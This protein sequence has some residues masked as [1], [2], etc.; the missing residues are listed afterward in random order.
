MRRCSLR[1]PMPVHQLNRSSIQR[2][3]HSSSVPG[4]TK[5]SISICSNS[6]SRK[7]KLPGV[8]SLRKER[9]I[10]AMPKGSLRRGGGGEVSWVYETGRGVLGREVDDG[11]LVGDGAD[12]GLE[13][14]VEHAGVGELAAAFGAAELALV[15]R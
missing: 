10:W 11:C 4:V 3:C 15:V 7:M 6:R 12:V 9:P 14:E 5:N 8:I 2:S 13:H 1:T